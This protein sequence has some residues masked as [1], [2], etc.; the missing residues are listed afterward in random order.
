[1]LPFYT[2]WK[3]QKT[4]GLVVFSRGLK[5]EYWFLA[6][7]NNPFKTNPFVVNFSFIHPENAR[8][9]EVFREYQMGTLAR[10]GLKTAFNK[11]F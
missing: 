3:H 6:V 10:S 9:L 8:K 11:V 5:W 2:P 1:M 7:I 4:S